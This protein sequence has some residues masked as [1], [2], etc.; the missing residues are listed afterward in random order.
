M[1]NVAQQGRELASVPCLR[2][3]DHHLSVCQDLLLLRLE[4]FFRQ[5]SLRLQFSESL[6]RSCGVCAFEF[7][8]KDHGQTNSNYHHHYTV[9]P[10]VEHLLLLSLIRCSGRTA[11]VTG[12]SVVIEA[13]SALINFT[14]HAGE[15][16][17][18]TVGS[19][20]FCYMAS[21]RCT[22]TLVSVSFTRP[23]DSDSVLVSSGM[24]APRA[25]RRTCFPS[26]LGHPRP[27]FSSALPT[28]SWRHR[29]LLLLANA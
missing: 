6:D 16:Y 13:R 2:W 20:C 1:A 28:L 18:A 17:S 11:G 27:N 12:K 3:F 22:V 25:R 8:D 5:Q 19:P 15:P 4:F 7:C 26:R 29:L 14:V 24:Q 9:G 10:W 21:R 23:S